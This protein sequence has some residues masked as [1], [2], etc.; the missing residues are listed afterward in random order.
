[1]ACVRTARPAATTSATPLFPADHAE[2]DRT[3]MGSAAAHRALVR[4]GSARGVALVMHGLAPGTRPVHRDG[5]VPPLERRAAAAAHRPLVTTRAAR[6]GRHAACTGSAGTRRQ[7]AGGQPCVLARRDGAAR[8]V[9]AGAL[10]RQVG[11]EA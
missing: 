2:H 11:R 5:A 10:R 7:D 9:P 4:T 3:P 6:T 1:M 8:A